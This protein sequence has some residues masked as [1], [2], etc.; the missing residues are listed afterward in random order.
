MNLP[1]ARVV[2]GY[3]SHRD[4]LVR[5]GNVIATVVACNQP[6]YPLYLYFLVSEDIA[7]AF[8]TLL[9]TPFFL[10]VPAVAR[11][12]S[13]AGRALL[14]LTGMANT[15]LGAKAFG[16]AS[17]VELFFLPCIMLA[18]M[19]FRHSERRIALVL[20]GLGLVL[21]IGLHGHY[22]APLHLFSVEENARFLGVNAFSVGTLS[23]FVGL[24]FANALA[25][26][27]RERVE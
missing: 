3:I 25:D 1:V 19:M 23:A 10:V 15:A 24:V 7:V 13:L 2:R 9:S 5:A 11:R 20:A 4:P 27:E 12:R 21:Y 17:G 8:L 26:V 14:P 16:E 22:G 18:T 6:F